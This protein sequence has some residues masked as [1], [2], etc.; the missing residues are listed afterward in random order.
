MTVSSGAQTKENP[1]P[2]QTGGTTLWGYARM[3][4]TPRAMEI[5]TGKNAQGGVGLTSAVQMWPT[6]T[7]RDHKDTG[8]CKKVPVNSLLGRAV[9]PSIQHGSLNPTWVEWLMGFPAEWTDLEPSETP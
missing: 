6:P 8:D 9:E 3:W 4:P 7:S 5:P 1:T 2:G